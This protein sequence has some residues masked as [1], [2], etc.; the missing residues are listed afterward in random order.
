M[1]RSF[2]AASLIVHT[3][4]KPEEVEIVHRVGAVRRRADAS[5]K[6]ETT[7]HYCKIRLEQDQDETV[8]KEKEFERKETCNHGKC[9]VY[10]WENPVQTTRRH[11][12]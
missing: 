11:K 5:W 4:I 9:M 12:G 2:P 1:A 10:K 8:D 7:R 6:S 3:H